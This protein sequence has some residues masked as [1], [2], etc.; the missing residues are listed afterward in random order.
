MNKPVLILAA[1][2]LGAASSLSF[3]A[4]PTDSIA[5]LPFVRPDAPTPIP[6]PMPTAMPVPDITGAIPRMNRVAPTTALK[7]GLDALSNNNAAAALTARDSLPE[8]SL[9]N[10]ILTWAIASSGLAGVPSGDIAA[11][12]TRL[13]GWPGLS[14]LRAQSERALYRENPP[15]LDVLAAFGST[16]PETTEG[17]I[18]L[19]RALVASGK[20]A[21]ASRTL[22][23][24]WVSEALDKNIEDRI[25][26]EFSALFSPA[27]HR[28]RMDCLMYRGRTAQAKRFADMG[29]AHSLYMAWSAVTANA[30][31]AEALLSAVDGS[32]ASDPGLAFARIEHLRRQEKYREAAQLLERVTR[33]PAKLISTGEW[34]NERRIVARGLADQGDF[35]LAYRTVANHVA[36]SGPDK[37]DAEFHAGWYALRALK[38]PAS[39]ETHFRKILDASSRPLSASRAWYWLGRAAEDGAPGNAHDFYKKAAQYPGTFYGQLAATRMDIRTLDVTY[40]SPS[41]VDRQKFEA[42]EVVQAIA[43]LDAAGHDRRASALYR[44]LAE[45]MN[46]PGELAL[47]ASRAEVQGD[48]ALALQIGKTAFGRGV[49]VA[50]LA[51]PV[52]VIPTDANIAGSGKAL[53]Y[54]IARQESAF[55]PA[56]I[57][58]ANARG[59]LQIL[60]TTA[61]G[62]AKRHGISFQT[63]KLTTDAAYNATLGAHYL[64]EQID[65]F[66]GSYILTFIAYNAGPRRV[67]DWIER[68]GDPRGKSIDEV[69]DWIERIPFPET[70]NY[71]QRV[72]ENY[73]VYKTR[74]GQK[75][76]IESDLRFGR[77]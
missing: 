27:D 74:L 62:V 19:A 44:A 46:S 2:G 18:I 52:G 39:A 58:P 56:A 72:M 65:T 17:T 14:G 28:A 75:A 15:A 70:R 13:K 6:T 42:R 29:E 60:P 38:D 45:E 43:R 1:L 51:F 49:N 40:P 73:Q 54:A 50:A 20:I 8:G 37:A 47:L 55:N 34:W 61:Q 5:P 30:K 7:A 53:A 32:L 16:K 22:R 59:L 35:K 10:H 33:D 63:E 9:D 76:D 64:G 69:V 57:S 41:A 23:G 68:Y 66:G 24:I 67:N 25:L 77:L 31:N 36:T 21:D 26:R 3:A 12:Q 11:A 4:P 71:V 48:H